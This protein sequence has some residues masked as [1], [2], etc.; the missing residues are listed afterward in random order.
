MSCSLD[1]INVSP[2]TNA[3]QIAELVNA[4]WR[5]QYPADENLTFWPETFFDWQ[6]LQAQADHP[7]ICLGAYVNN[8]LI[9]AYCGDI[10]TVRQPDGAEERVTFLSCV[11]VQSG[12]YRHHASEKLLNAMRDWSDQNGSHQFF[13]FVNPR[14]S[15]MVGRRY[16]TS[17]RGFSHSFLE[18]ARQWQQHPD[19]FIELKSDAHG[20]T[21]TDLD[22]AAHFLRERLT[23]NAKDTPCSLLWSPFRIKHQLRFKPLADCVQIRDGADQGVCSFSM[24]PTHGGWQVG[25]IDFLAAS[26]ERFDLIQLALQNALAIMQAN[27]CKRVLTLGGPTNRDTDLERLGFMPCI[28]SFAP[29]LVTWKDNNFFKPHSRLAFVYR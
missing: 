5:K 27:G 3:N 11:S 25:Y 18:G 7:T 13:G 8:C 21:D 2:V 26:G 14:E 9:G 17:R 20:T 24:L 28:P 22:S 23:E 29:L 12:P 16:W 6:F 10:W 15:A 1:D 4:V 19:H